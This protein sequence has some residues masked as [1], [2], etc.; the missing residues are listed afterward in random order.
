MVNYTLSKLQKILLSCQESTEECS[1]E[2]SS[3]NGVDNSNSDVELYSCDGKK[4]Q[5]KLISQANLNDLDLTVQGCFIFKNGCSLKREFVFKEAEIK[6]SD[7]ILLLSCT[8][9][10]G[11]SLV[12]LKFRG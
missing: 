4:K 5:V 12:K 3:T 7:N 10:S 9:I 1:Q 8:D 2:I 6:H 11:L